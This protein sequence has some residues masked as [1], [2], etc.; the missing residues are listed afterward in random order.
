MTHRPRIRLPLPWGPVVLVAAAGSGFAVA[1]LTSPYVYSRYFPWI[2]GRSTGL[3]AYCSMWAMCLIGLWL[4]HPWRWRRPLLHPE[5]AL[6]LHAALAAVTIVLTGAHVVSLALDRYAGV[7]WLGVV[8]PGS[9]T[10][11]PVAVGVGVVA[12]WLLV[13]IAATARL[14]A[15]LIGRAWLPIH[16]LALP[17]FTAVFCHSVLTGT[18]TPTLRIAYATSGAAVVVTYL[19]SKLGRPYSPASIRAIQRRAHASVAEHRPSG[20]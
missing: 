2:I 7:G 15:R 12:L 14:G 6:R 1:R 8:L 4:R 18:D 10:Y 5:T 17:V 13:A 3:A 9:A 11:R 19:T 16:R 20:P